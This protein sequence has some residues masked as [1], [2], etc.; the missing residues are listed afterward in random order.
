MLDILRLTAT[1]IGYINILAF[2][3]GAVGLFDFHWSL[4]SR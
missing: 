3:L 1:A 2:L 4:V